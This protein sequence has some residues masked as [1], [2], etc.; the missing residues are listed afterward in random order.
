MRS[1]YAVALGSNMRHVRHG[2]P[3]RVIAAA[4]RMLPG[5]LCALSPV[6]AS[7]P[8]GPSPRDFANAVAIVETKRS[9]TKM[10]AALQAIEHEFGRRRG[11]RWGARVL[12]LDIV[13]WSGGVS[14]SPGLSIPHPAWRGRRFVVAPL[15]AI[16]PDWRDPL[17]GLSPRHLLAR[18]DRRRRAP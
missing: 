1:T 4:A 10:L 13:L 11:R 7:R 16:A 2:P 18:L 12:D 8:L 14:A 15:A 3:A 9:P 6:M 5:R 17:S